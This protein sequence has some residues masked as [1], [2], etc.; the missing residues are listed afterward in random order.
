MKVSEIMSSPI[1]TVREEATLKEVAQTM[2][3]H[4]FGCVPVVDKQGVM[5]G[6][7]TESD[8]AAK[9]R[10]VPFTT[11]RMPQLFGRWLGKSGVEQL[12]ESAST[13]PASDVMSRDVITVTEEVTIEEVLELMLR[14]DVNRIPV[15]RDRVPVGIVARYDLLKLMLRQ[16]KPM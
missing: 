6:I 15:L 13:I 10:G 14:H 11:F 8:F 3:D 1:I 2:L 7:I 16:R 9:N 12:Y 4:S 5:T